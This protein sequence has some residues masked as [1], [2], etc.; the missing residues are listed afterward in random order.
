MRRAERK[1][2][3][4]RE[5]SVPRCSAAL[6]LPLGSVFSACRHPGGVTDSFRSSSPFAETVR[7]STSCRRERCFLLPAGPCRGRSAASAFRPVQQ[8]LLP[9]RRVP[10]TMSREGASLISGPG[11]FGCRNTVCVLCG[12]WQAVCPWKLCGDNWGNGALAALRYSESLRRAIE[13]S[14][15]WESGC[16]CHGAW[17][18]P[19]TVSPSSPPGWSSMRS[20]SPRDNTRR[21]E[22]QE[23]HSAP[24]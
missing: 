9:G 5:V 12:L 16:R 14:W 15:R 4:L 8:R 3:G 1:E 24:M 2:P 10:G 7:G 13:M 21:Q 6:P 22:S 23:V 20:M 11:G 18:L 19:S 17:L